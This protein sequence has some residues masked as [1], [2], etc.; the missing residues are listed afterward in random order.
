[1]HEDIRIDI[2]RDRFVV[3]HYHLF[4]NGGSTLESVLRRNFGAACVDVHGHRDDD[5]VFADDILGV[6]RERGDIRAICSHHLRYP[7]PIARGFVFFDVCFLRHPLARTRS[8]YHYGRRLDPAHWLG[9]LARAG[10]EAAF[11]AHLV[12]RM[13]H[14]LCDV[15]VHFIAN[16]C[17][18]TRPA[19]TRDLEIAL[20][21]V[22]AMALPG[23]VE[24]FDE[25]LVTAEYFLHPAFPDLQLDYVAQNVSSP[26]GHDPAA[27][28][29][30]L[31]DACR[32]AWSTDTFDQVLALNAGDLSLY[33]TTRAEV[34][35]RFALVPDHAQRLAM[36]RERCRAR[37]NGNV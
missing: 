23:V 36:F 28:I 14:M 6:L 4:K 10:D 9:T 34:L 12:E 21:T 29:D 20:A 11:V 8:L 17:A 37:V 30:S 19:G 32:V 7:R 25:S 16:A 24:L 18:F 15:Q 31:F 13:P 26:A 27:T 3:L 35:R 1:M 33:D 5:A 22:E 2:P